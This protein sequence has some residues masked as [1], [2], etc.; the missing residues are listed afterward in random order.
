[1][2]RLGLCCLN[3]Q[4][5]KKRIFCSR[6]VTRARFTEEKARELTLL[7]IADAEIM[8]RWNRDHGIYVFRLSSDLFPHATDDETPYDH[9]F[10]IPA[11][12]HLGK[13]A[14]LY[15][16]RITMHPGQYNQVGAVSKEVFRKTVRDL[17]HHAFILDTMGMDES[18]ILCIH[19]GGVYGDKETTMRRWMDQF[20]DLP[21]SVKKRV[22]IENCE[23]A[24]STEDC[25]ELAWECNIPM[26]FDTHHDACYRILHPSYQ[27]EDVEDQLPLVIDTWKGVTPLMHISEQRPDARIGAHS[28]MIQTIP[29]YLLETVASGVSVDLEV[30]A[31]LKEQAIFQ[32]YE[33]YPDVFLK[34]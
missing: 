7:N 32:L 27:P 19:G 31:K 15:G 28:D 1:M 8:M 22:A 29:S 13:M 21:Q 12:Q 14:R 20:C 4:L 30:E 5:R 26:I 10:A 16:Q 6:T 24:Y 17:E 3:T 9:S 34:K 23:R 2:L 11:L 33:T 25:L 18:S